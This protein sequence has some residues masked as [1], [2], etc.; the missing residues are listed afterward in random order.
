M[1]G[2][3]EKMKRLYKSQRN[4]IIAGVCGGIAEYLDVDP[5]LVRIIAVLFF[6]TGGA[7]LI[8]YII[9]VIIM[10]Q[11]PSQAP[12][13][14]DPTQ[15]QSASSIQDVSTKGNDKIGSLIIGI[16]MIVFGLHFLLRNIPFFHPYYWW[17]WDMG[18]KFFW[19]SVLILVGLF[20]IVR[21]AR[22]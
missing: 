11:Q 7:T 12:I 9:G 17:F 20:V 5:V 13:A 10:P 14:I 18:W 2:G 4:K 8:A 3:G 1:P 19:P 16:I 22:K 15:P 6:F 21:G